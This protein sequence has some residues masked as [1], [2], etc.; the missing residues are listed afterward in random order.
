[1]NEELRRF[2][3]ES[4]EQGQSREVIREVLLQAGWPERDLRNALAAFAEVDFPVAVPRPR[5][6]LHAREAFF[7]LVSFIA[8]YV[9]A[10]SFGA[11]VFGL[12]ERTFPDALDRAGSYSSEG[13]ATAI[14]AVIVAFPAYLLLM[15]WLGAQVVADPERRESLVR[16]WL[17]YL[18]LVVGAAIILG[19]L[20][21]LLASFLTGEPTL[22]FVLKAVAILIITSVIL[23]YYL[24]DMRQVESKAGAAGGATTPTLRFIVVGVVIVVVLCVGYAI[25]L[26]GAPS[27]QRDLR[28]DE[29][30]IDNL[31]NISFNID[32]YWELNGKLPESL[33]DMSGPRYSVHSIEDPETGAPYEYHP[34]E[35]AAY[36]L[37]A[38]FATDS[39][40]RNDGDLSFSDLT[41]G[42]GVGRAC[43][44]LEAKS[45]SNP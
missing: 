34:T 21:A 16:R 14:A 30:R 35:E 28:A 31:A 2:I 25:F 36:E 44:A 4:L 8:L 19:D 37:C 39:S 13:H 40:R 22:R 45:R 38:I 23:G 42:H 12:I 6:Y 26:L 32:T 3:K 43:F 18:T 10:F 1:M 24:W 41:W 17:T 11:L 9:T 27:Q 7:Y 20:I 29:R 15:R 5:P 33:V